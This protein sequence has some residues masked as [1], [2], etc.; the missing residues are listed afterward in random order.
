MENLGQRQKL[1]ANISTIDCHRNSYPTTTICNISGVDV[2]ANAQLSCLEA[3]NPAGVSAV[4]G[5]SLD[6]KTAGQS[7]DK[8][9]LP[10]RTKWYLVVFQG[11]DE[12]CPGYPE[13]QKKEFATLT[14]HHLYSKKLSVRG[15]SL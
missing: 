6:S 9:C 7:E 14:R 8:V 15:L 4:S 1:C 2:S 10:T 13:S 12:A 5:R 11:K 3:L